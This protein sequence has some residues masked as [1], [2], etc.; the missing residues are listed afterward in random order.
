MPVDTLSQPHIAAETFHQ[1]AAENNI[2]QCRVDLE[3]GDL[4][5]F[6]T[7]CIHEVPAIQGDLP[8]VVWRFLSA[9]H[10]NTRKCLFGLDLAAI[11]P[12]FDHGAPSWRPHRA[13]KIP[14]EGRRVLKFGPTPI[15]RGPLRRD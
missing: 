2:A 14:P 9:T 1:C 7:R 10:P 3:P 8:R 4:Y 11:R 5:F 15:F 6:N 12:L 13:Q